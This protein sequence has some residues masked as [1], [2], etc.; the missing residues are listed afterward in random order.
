MTWPV[1]YNPP[2]MADIWHSVPMRGAV[3]GALSAAWI[4][5]AAFRSWKSFDDVWHYDWRLA[6]F[7]WLQGA[8]VGAVTALGVDLT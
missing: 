5:F 7:R 4:D 3:A 8:V 2:T 1:R 6:A